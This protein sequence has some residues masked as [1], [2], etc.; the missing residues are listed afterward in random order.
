MM[1]AKLLVATIVQ[2]FSIAPPAASSAALELE[3]GI[4]LS[5]A[6]FYAFHRQQGPAEP[7]RDSEPPVQ[8]EPDDEPA[9]ANERE[10]VRSIQD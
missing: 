4:T 3:P 6:S 5:R 9:D 10:A 7:Q 2:R 1:E 8:P